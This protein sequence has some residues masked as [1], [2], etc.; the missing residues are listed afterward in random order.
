MPGFH[1]WSLSLF[2]VGGVRV[3][4]HALLLALAATL[5]LTAAQSETGEGTWWVLLLVLLLAS[6]A[7]HELGHCRAAIRRGGYPH[8][9][10]LW[11]FG[12]LV[13]LSV[14]RSA[15][16][17]IGVALAGPM[18]NAL[19][20]ALCGAWVLASGGTWHSLG[21]DLLS[22]PTAAGPVTW[23]LVPRLALWLNFWLVAVNALPAWP[24]DGGRALRGVMWLL[25]GYRYALRSEQAGSRICGGVLCLAPAVGRALGGALPVFV[26]LPLIALGVYLLASTRPSPRRRRDAA[27]LRLDGETREADDGALLF[28]MGEPSLSEP[29]LNESAIGESAFNESASAGPTA[30]GQAVERR[31]E[32]ILR[33]KRQREE[34]ED[35][36]VDDILSR[37]PEVG[38]EGLSA[39]ER[40]L[41]ERAGARY[42]DRPR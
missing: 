1:L 34:E 36:R 32:E 18:V 15:A 5:L 17:D 22:P 29:P 24:M 10:V 31:Y 13:Q 28:G 41:L 12:G 2:R 3:R 38:L 14:P 30:I 39:E 21:A 37:L 42:R 19:L 35:R 11:P 7:L 20:A 27:H 16:N 25:F 8:E 4:L 6:V 26:E 9:V 23:S 33:R 40:E